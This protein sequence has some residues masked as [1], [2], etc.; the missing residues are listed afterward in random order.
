[1]GA[2]IGVGFYLY[3]D[4][5]RENQP[6]LAGSFPLSDMVLSPVILLPQQGV[7]DF[8]VRI[9]M[10]EKDDWTYIYAV[11]TGVTDAPA[12]VKVG[13]AEF[14]QSLGVYTFTT[15]SQPPRTFTFTPAQPP[16][17]DIGTVLPQPAWAPVFPQHTGSDIWFLATKLD[18][19]LLALA[20]VDFHDYIIWFPAESGLEPV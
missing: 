4:M 17:T 20:G 13:A 18:M 12:K 16:S 6:P 7:V 10:A 19:T 1:M 9:L 14:D 3:D 15:D 2:I 8:P 5:R 11:K